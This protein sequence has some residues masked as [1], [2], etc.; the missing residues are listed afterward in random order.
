MVHVD[1]E[2][3]QA[4][5][6]AEVAER[7]GKL[8]SLPAYVEQVL[9]GQASAAEQHYATKFLAEIRRRLSDL[10]WYMRSLNESIAR[11]AN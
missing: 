7:W 11:R 6:D 4:W 1:A 2:K 10:S 3:A 5:S 9:K 8:F